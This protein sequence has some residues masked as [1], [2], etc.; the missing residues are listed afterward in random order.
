MLSIQNRYRG[1]MHCALIG[2]LARR[3]FKDTGYDISVSTDEAF[4]DELIKNDQFDTTHFL[5]GRPYPLLNPII[6]IALRHHRNPGERFRSVRRMYRQNDL[7][8]NEQW[9]D[10]ALLYTATLSELIEG[11]DPQEAIDFAVR[12]HAGRDTFSDDVEEMRLIVFGALKA[13]DP[14]QAPL[15]HG[16]TGAALVGAELGFNLTAHQTPL[17]EQQRVLDIADKLFKKAYGY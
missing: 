11:K 8:W 2:A 3:G 1:A 14:I 5:H 7:D 6:Q 16:G 15:D 13:K 17:R 4:C 9:H 10:F 12:H